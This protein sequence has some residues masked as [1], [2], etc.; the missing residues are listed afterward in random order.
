[1]RWLLSDVCY[2]S[3]SVGSHKVDHSCSTNAIRH[4]RILDGFPHSSNASSDIGAF[5][6]W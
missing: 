2:L 1:M 4:V 6:Y 5:A 3:K